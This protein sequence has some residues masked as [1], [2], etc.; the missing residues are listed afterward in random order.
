MQCIVEG[1]E[2]P[3]VA[4]GYC[5]MHRWRVRYK[6]EPGPAEQLKPQS[7]KGTPEPCTVPGCE[8][9]KV[10]KTYCKLHY[11]RIRRTGSLG[12]PQPLYQP[13]GNGY[14]DKKGYRRIHVKDGRRILEHVHVMEQH[15]GRRL[16]PGENIHHKNGIRSDNRLENLELWVS[17]QPTGQ[18][19]EDLV[20]FVVEHYP[21]EVR[22]ALA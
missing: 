17:M 4:R 8:R 18:R 7:A 20:K 14:V 22:R 12:P 13:K 1:C 19:V 2:K 11:E 5:E 15:L 21:E 16:E 3:N 6:G 9:R 10:G